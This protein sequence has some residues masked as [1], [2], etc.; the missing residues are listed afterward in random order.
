[1]IPESPIVEACVRELGRRG[2]RN[3]P[4]CLIADL[5]RVLE[6]PFAVMPPEGRPA[7]ESDYWRQFR[8]LTGS[9]RWHQCERWIHGREILRSPY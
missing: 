8:R 4:R 6:N 9:P 5:V 2:V 3:L 1:M 7:G